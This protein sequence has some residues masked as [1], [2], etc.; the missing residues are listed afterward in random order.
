MT[1]GSPYTTL[2]N[3]GY[4]IPALPTPRGSYVTARSGGGLTFTAGHLPIQDNKVTH[5]GAVTDDDAITYAQ[6]AALVCLLN[7]LA[8][9]ETELGSLDNLATVLKVT[10]YIASSSDFQSHPM[11]LNPVSELLSEIFGPQGRHARSV[12]GVTSLPL[13][14]TVELELIVT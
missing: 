9:V 13:N 2:A 8:A 10:A 4:S 6:N 7:A 11:V 5:V 3:L 1:H 14:S 12:V